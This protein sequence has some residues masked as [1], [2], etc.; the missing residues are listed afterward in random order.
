MVAD[1]SIFCNI[2]AMLTTKLDQKITT[3]TYLLNVIFQ[4]EKIV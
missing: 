1:I 4:A 2:F 3:L